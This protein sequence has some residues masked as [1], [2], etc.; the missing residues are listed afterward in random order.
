MEGGERLG[1][2]VSGGEVLAEEFF[3]A[4]VRL[5]GGVELGIGAG[6]IGAE[7]DL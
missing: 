5:D 2:V 7:V 3:E 6:G 4:V 1:A